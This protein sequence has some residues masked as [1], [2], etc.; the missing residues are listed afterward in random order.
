MYLSSSDKK[1]LKKFRLV[2]YLN[3]LTSVIAVQYSA[4]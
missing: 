4:N 1:D 2:K 3:P